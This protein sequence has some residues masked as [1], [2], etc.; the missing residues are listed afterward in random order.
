MN[1]LSTIGQYIRDGL[2]HAEIVVK[3]DV[4]HAIQVSEDWIA[5]IRSAD[6]FA[7]VAHVPSEVVGTAEG[8]AGAVEAD[9]KDAAI[10][11]GDVADAVVKDVAPAASEPP[12]E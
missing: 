8:V 5:K 2:S 1:L 9:V 6:G 7:L 11:A 10:E 12:K 4:E 3:L